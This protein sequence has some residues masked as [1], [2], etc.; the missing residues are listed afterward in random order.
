MQQSTKTIITAALQQ[1]GNYTPEQI[2]A[3]FNLLEGK[4]QEKKAIEPLLRLK[5]VTRLLAVSRA[6]LWRIERAGKLQRVMI[7]SS[8]RYKQSDIENLITSG[9][10]G[11]ML[12]ERRDLPINQNTVTK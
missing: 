8:P 4:Y 9:H 2:N 10:K 5:D 1:D 3:V 11:I 6:T 7:G 12:H